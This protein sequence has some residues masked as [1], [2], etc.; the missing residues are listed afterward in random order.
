MSIT[1]N[2]HRVLNDIEDAAA[3][4]GREPSEVRLVAVTKTRTVDEIIEVVEAGVVHL[5]ENRLQEAS[6]KIPEISGGPVWHLVGHLQSNKAKVATGLFDWI[7]SI[8]SKKIIDL[9]SARASEE[10]KTVNALVQVDISGEETKYGA[11]PELARKLIEYAAGIEGIAVRGLMTIGSFGVSAD[12]TR[13]EFARMRE[14]FERFR[15][16]PVTGPSMKELSMGMSGDYTLA[17]EEGSTMVRVGTSIF[18]QRNV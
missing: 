1:E 4:A 17:I 11:S 5:G 6:E 3:R 14:L 13:A 8:D 15:D 12:V 7:D 16:D 18:G 9:I 10:N 2:V